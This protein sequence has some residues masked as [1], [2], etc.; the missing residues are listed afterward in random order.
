MLY[1]TL[2]I[3]MLTVI[4]SQAHAGDL[5]AGLERTNSFLITD[6]VPVLSLTGLIISHSFWKRRNFEMY[7]YH[8]RNGAALFRKWAY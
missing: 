5:V 1:K 4:Y 8:W 7:L 2:L 3:C 6:L